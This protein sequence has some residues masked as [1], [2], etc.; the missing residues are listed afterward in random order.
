LQSKENY[1][2]AFAAIETR[3]NTY[4]MN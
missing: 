1:A 2:L 4:W 3:H